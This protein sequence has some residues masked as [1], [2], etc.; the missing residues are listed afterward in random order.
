VILQPKSI[1]KRAALLGAVIV[2]AAVGA[3]WVIVPP[4]PVYQGK[5]LSDWM[6]GSSERLNREQLQTLGPGAVTWLSYQARQSRPGMG[7]PFLGEASKL[8]KLRVWLREKFHRDAPTKADSVPFE[9]VVA[10]EAL[11]PD[12]ALAVPALIDV[13]RCGEH[14]S[15]LVACEALATIGPASWPAV[16]AA[17]RHGTQTQRLLLIEKLERR[18]SENVP[19]Q[20]ANE[21]TEMVV[22]L[23]ESMHDSDPDIGAYAFEAVKRCAKAR[24]GS[25]ELH[26]GI[27]AGAE[28][29]ASLSNAQQRVIADA[30]VELELDAAAATPALKALAD[31]GDEMTRAHITAALAVVDPENPK[32]PA[33]LHEFAASPDKSLAGFAEDALIHAGR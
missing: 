27:R 7:D 1:R 16:A 17:I 13:V 25:R 33:A 24:S 21:L 23:F 28:G 26:A 18:L 4:E 6:F 3:W 2:G 32:W 9:S 11:G 29:M 15:R 31:I 22:L 10:L 5:R 8:T 19:P 30:F 20:G 14:D 12:A